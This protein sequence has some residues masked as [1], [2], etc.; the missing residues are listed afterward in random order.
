MREDLP[1]DEIWGVFPVL[2]LI[3]LNIWY[4]FNITN[5]VFLS[6]VIALDLIV[7]FPLIA[8]IMK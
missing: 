4:L 3:I 5:I 8:Y 7:F 1:P 6:I 2:G